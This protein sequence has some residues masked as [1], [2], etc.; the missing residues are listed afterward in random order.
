MSTSGAGRGA[1]LRQQRLL[2]LEPLGRAL[3][4]ELHAL[5]GGSGRRHEGQRAFARQRHRRQAAERP[6]RELQHLAELALGLG[7][8]VVEAHVDAAEQEARGPAAA[9]HAAA[10]QA[11]RAGCA[12]ASS[13]DISCAARRAARPSDGRRVRVTRTLGPQTLTIATGR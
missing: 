3:L 9:D 6:A 12:H 2:E 7:I 4:D 8:G 1:G 10:E 13:S 11:H 5:G